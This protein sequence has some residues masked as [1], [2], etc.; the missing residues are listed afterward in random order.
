V[1]LQCGQLGVAGVDVVGQ[2]NK[3]P[4]L[5]GNPVIVVSAGGFHSAVLTVQG[6]VF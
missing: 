4:G 6:D 3:V 2:P 5:D 1:R